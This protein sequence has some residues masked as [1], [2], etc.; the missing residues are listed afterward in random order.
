MEC[1]PPEEIRVTLPGS[2]APIKLPARW[3]RASEPSDAVTK[4]VEGFYADAGYSIGCLIASFEPAFQFWGKH[5][6]TS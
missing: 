4:W 2:L 1:A 6:G 5:G 3:S